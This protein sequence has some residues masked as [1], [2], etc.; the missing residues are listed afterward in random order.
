MLTAE[1]NDL[2]CQVGRGTPGG[3]FQRRY[4][5]PVALSDELPPEGPPVPVRLLGEDL[6]LF[7]DESGQP[8]LLGLHC[9]HRGA[10]LSYGRIEDGGLRCIYHGWLY[11]VAGHCLEQPG[12]PI[13][14]RFNHK[15]HQLSYP[16]REAGGVI[17]AYLGPGEAPLVPAYSF[18]EGGEKQWWVTKVFHECNYQQGNEGN[19]DTAHSSFLHRR[20]GEKTAR[21]HDYIANGGFDLIE[22][23]ETDFGVRLYFV[24]TR[25]ESGETYVRIENYVFPSIGAFGA[26]HW[27]VPIDDEHH[28]QYVFWNLSPERG[29][30]TLVGELGSDYRL[31]RTKDNRYLQDRQAMLTQNYSGMGMSNYPQDG[32]VTEGEGPIQD[33]TQEHLGH[34]DLGI[35]AT[36][37]AMLQA[38]RAVQAGQE[39][40]H[41]VRDP[42]ENNFDHL[43]MKADLVPAGKDWRGYWNTAR[44]AV[45]ADR[46]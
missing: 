18:L 35:V 11:D 37:K 26:V 38:I 4:W 44:H 40:P 41:V 36:R 31:Y 1:E 7:R 2:L 12:E 27:H 24:I 5:Q 33:R 42:S 6:V 3:E 46:R 32:C 39:P 17:L 21:P 14:S 10:D 20:F 45:S 15:I 19:L 28:W 13:G 30:E 43:I 29:R 22:V 34:T 16:C 23:E 8:G 25:L 9:A